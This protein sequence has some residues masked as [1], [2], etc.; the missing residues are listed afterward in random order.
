[1]EK[2]SPLIQKS[3]LQTEKLTGKGKYMVK[4]GNHLHTNMI[5]KAAIG[6]EHKWT[7]LGMHLKLKAAT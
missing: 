6:G 7:I 4:V 3:K 1:M 5:P 2:K